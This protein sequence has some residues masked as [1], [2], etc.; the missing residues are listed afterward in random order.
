MNKPGTHTAPILAQIQGAAVVYEHP[1]PASSG[2]DPGR[3][4]AGSTRPNQGR[5]VV[6]ITDAAQ[7]GAYLSN[8]A[9]NAAAPLILYGVNNCAF[10]LGNNNTAIRGNNNTTQ[11]P[12]AADL[13]A[14]LDAIRTVVDRQSK[15]IDMLLDLVEVLTAKVDRLQTNNR[16]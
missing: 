16:V 1:I 13:A 2:T 4:P 5:Q 8:Y 11:I 3:R 10:A 15:T 7:L 12:R 9:P 6:T 14:A